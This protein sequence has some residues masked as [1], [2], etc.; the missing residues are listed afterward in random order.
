MVNKFGEGRVFIAGGGSLRDY[1]LFAH[2]L[3]GTLP[4]AAQWVFMLME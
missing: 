1:C 4:D 2:F 3:Y